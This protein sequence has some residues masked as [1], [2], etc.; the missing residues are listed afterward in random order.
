MWTMRDAGVKTHLIPFLFKGE[1]WS[2]ISTP[3]LYSEEQPSGFV[4][5][6]AIAESCSTKLG[7]LFDA[8]A[9]LR[10]ISIR[11]KRGV[12]FLD[13]PFFKVIFISHAPLLHQL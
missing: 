4:V 6:V 13:T 7:Y 8:L 2:G 3:R 5:C 9:F 1:P 11:A 10:L 12:T